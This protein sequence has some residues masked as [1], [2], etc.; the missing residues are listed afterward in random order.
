MF[1]RQ[2][3]NNFAE[4]KGQT[5]EKLNFDSLF[6]LSYLRKFTQITSKVRKYF[7]ASK[8]EMWEMWVQLAGFEFFLSSK[9]VASIS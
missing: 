5:D 4:L 2:I 9:D 1:V 8:R 7:M 3:S 6:I